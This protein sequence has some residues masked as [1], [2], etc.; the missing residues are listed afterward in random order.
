MTPPI[1]SRRK[2]KLYAHDQHIVIVNGRQERLAHPLMKA[3]L[4]A[5]YLPDYPNITVEIRIGDKYKPDVVAFPGALGQREG[6]PVF[7]GE[8]GQVGM[9]KIRSLAR[10]YPTTHLAIAKWE[11][12]LAP[13]AEIVADALDGVDRSAPFDLLNF[14]ADSAERF[15]D[16][17]GNI[18]LTQ[19]DVEWLRLGNTAV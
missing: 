9:A 18:S 15:I 4:W 19:A 16:E 3:F 5:L 8:A 13:L 12:R 2:W 10:R 7:W 1:L 17:H 14:P 6:K 11:T